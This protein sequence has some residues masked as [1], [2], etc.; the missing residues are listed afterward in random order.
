MN[1]CRKC[2]V[3][4]AL[5]WAVDAVGPA[6]AESPRLDPRC[7]E[8]PQGV[9]WPLL[10]R[11]RTSLLKVADQKTYVSTD[12]GLN[13]SLLGPV[14]PEGQRPMILERRPGEL[15][16]VVGMCPPGTIRFSIF[17]RD[18]INPK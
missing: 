5:C 16:I 4:L 8:L 17:E 12:E 10:R 14:F 1:R 11:N 7:R 13:W 18:F 3:L 2:L 9:T 15:W 6:M